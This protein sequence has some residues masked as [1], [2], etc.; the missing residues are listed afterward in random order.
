MY[1]SIIVPIYNIE[2][3]VARCIDSLLQQDF[4]D[5]EVLLVDDGS[6]DNSLS[7][8]EKYKANKKIKILHKNNGG[9]VS[10]RKYGASKASGE[11]IINV[12]GDDYIKPNSLGKLYSI[13]KD[14]DVD[15]LAL[16]YDK[17]TGDNSTRIDNALDEGMYEAPYVASKFL[18]DAE[19][20]YVNSGLINFSIWSKVVKRELY[21]KC[22]SMVNDDVIQGEDILLNFLLFTNAEKIMVS[23]FAYYYY[24]VR[25]GSLFTKITSSDVIKLRLFIDE[26]KKQ[27]SEEYHNQ[28]RVFLFYRSYEMMYLRY[29]SMPYYKDFRSFVLEMK[30]NGIT[31]EVSK[32]KIV[33]KSIKSS[34]RLRLLS[35]CRIRLLYIFAK[36]KSR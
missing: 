3:L 15:M 13:L 31:D 9:L 17:L 29:Q 34:I 23:K 36:V 5:Y 30:E 33:N 35:K 19:Q 1:F 7:I 11:Y 27:V 10:A 21:Q 28:I 16:S 25:E 20:K 18:F 6:T 26:L 22:Q 32:I 4:E 24:C 2:N 14:K 12:D 8:C